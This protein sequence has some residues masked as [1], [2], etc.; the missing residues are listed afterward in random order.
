MVNEIPPNHVDD[1]PVVGPN[2]QDNVLIIPEHVLEDEDD[3]PKEEEFEEEEDPQEEE[4]DIEIDI[5]EDKNEPKLTYPYE[6]MD[7][8][9]PPS[10][11]SESEPEDEIKVENPIEHED[12]TVPASVHETAHALVEKKG[13]GKDEFC[14][15]LIL[16]LGNEVCSSV[17]QGTA[18]MDRLVKKLGNTED[19]VESKKLKKELEEARFSNT[20]LP[21]ICRMIKDNVDA[22][23]A[24]KRARQANVRNEASGSGPINGQ[25][26]APAARECIFAGFMKCNPTTFCGTEGAVELLRWF[27][28]TESVLESVNVLTEIQRMK[29]ELWYLKVKEYNIMAYS[30]RFN[31]LALMCPRMVEPERVK[32]HKCGKVGHQSRYC[33]QKNVAMG[34]NAPPIPTCYDCGEQGNTRNQCPKKVKQEEVGEVRGR[35][36]AIKDAQPKGPNVVTSTFLLNNRYA[37]VLFD[38]GFDRS[39]MDTRF[40]SMLDIDPVKIRSSYE[41][42]L[43]NGRVVG[44]NTVLKGCTLNLVNHVFEI[45]LMPIKLGTFDVIIENK[46]KVKQM[47]D[48]A[49][50]RDFPEVFPEELAPSEMKELLVQLQELLEKGFICLISLSWGALVLFVKKK[51]GSFRMCID[52]NELNKLT[53]KNRY[54]LSRINDLFDQLQGHLIDRSGVRVDPSKVK[55]IKSWAAPTTPIEKNGWGEEEAFQTLKWKL[56]STPILALPKE[57]EDFVVYCDASLK[58]YG[59]VFMQR[60][61]VIA[62]ASRQLKVHEENYTTHHLE[63]GAIVFALRLWRNYFG[64][65]DLVMHESH[66]SKYFIHSGSDMMCQDLKPLYWWPNMKVDIVTYVRLWRSLQET[67]GMNLDMSTAYHPQTDGQRERTI[68]TLED[69]LRACVIDFGSCWDRH[70]RLVE[71]SYNNSYYASIKA[72]PYEALYG[73]KYK[74]AKPL[75]FEVGDMVLLKVSL[76]K[77][78]ICFRKQKANSTYIRPFKILTRVGPVAYTLELPEEWKGIHSTFH[79][80]NLKKCLVKGDVVVPMYEIQLDDKFHMIEEPVEVVDR[81][82]KRLRK[83]QIPIVK[84]R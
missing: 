45:N 73:R 50:I 26:A 67:L 21:A 46:S 65:R 43:A 3:D 78:T 68:Q 70:I 34:A 33:K 24:A 83:S 82:V 59:A 15:K 84:V 39:F 23:I 6:E 2:H 27:K 80:S 53:V 60:E 55:A 66:K 37:F 13:K 29:H 5:K 63:L 1:A 64:L 14:G 54:P 79:I 9:N 51:D 36:Y 49:M 4:D 41:V 25:D 69:M 32:C 42:E 8:L 17:E 40:S 72:A 12:E 22:A 48:V 7:P 16:D 44:T 52:Y 38:S 18:A 31:E 10:P 56:C 76:W 19:K 77:G 35:A 58:G 74:R 62:Y 75:E 47:E 61:K 11:A 30:Q 20:F 28:K 81:E 57:T 71:F